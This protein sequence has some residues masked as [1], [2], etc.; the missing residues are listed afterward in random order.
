MSA[1]CREM[2]GRAGF[3]LAT[4]W[5]IWRRIRAQPWRALALVLV[6]AIPATTFTVLRERESREGRALLLVLLVESG[7]AVAH[8][9][10]ATTEALAPEL[11]QQAAL[12]VLP[13]E[14]LRQLLAEVGVLALIAGLLG[15]LLAAVQPVA[16]RGG[17]WPALPLALTIGLAAAAV[18]AWRAGLAAGL[19]TSTASAPHAGRTALRPSGWHARGRL[20][21]AIVHLWSTPGRSGLC[22]AAV[23][24]GCGSL[25]AYLRLGFGGPSRWVIALIVFIATF[26]V[27]DVGWLA[28]RDRGA[29]LTELRTQGLLGI[30][31]AALVVRE[32]AVLVFFGA[33]LGGAVG[34]IA[35][36]LFDSALTS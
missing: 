31:V 20:R 28:A 16:T 34:L 10:L 19:F 11:R 18:P 15:T 23:T 2:W 17:P 6:I 24:I 12:G 22:L 35:A 3:R 36:A 4:A 1:G 7:L 8:S 29:E 27:A 14:I 9:T 21:A 25:T 26:V 33:A 30:Q 32:I 13:G 5:L